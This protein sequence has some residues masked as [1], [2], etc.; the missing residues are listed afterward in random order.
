[1]PP[2]KL[3]SVTLLV[4]WCDE[5]HE[6]SV[7]ARVWK[8]IVAGK[9]IGRRGDAYHY[10]GER[11]ACRWMFNGREGPGSLV[12]SYSGGG[13]GYVGTWQD[14]LHEENFI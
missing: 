13:E 14:A 2:R 4:D 6:H 3:K 5:N 8:Q 10:E 9:P 1:M 12:V 7:P 11:F